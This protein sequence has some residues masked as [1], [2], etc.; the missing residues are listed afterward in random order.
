MSTMSV[1]L[2]AQMNACTQGYT[3]GS[4]PAQP[5]SFTAS[6]SGCLRAMA[7]RPGNPATHM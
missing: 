2:N 7:M 1:G 5:N 3:V 6:A 4:R